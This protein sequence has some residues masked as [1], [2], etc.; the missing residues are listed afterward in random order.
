LCFPTGWLNTPV[1]KLWQGFNDA[2]TAAAA[3]KTAAAMAPAIIAAC[4]ASMIIRT[5]HG[6]TANAGPDYFIPLKS[7]VHMQETGALQSL[8]WLLPPKARAWKL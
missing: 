8:F 7:Y 2:V 5:R 4:V 3:I 6:L 1:A